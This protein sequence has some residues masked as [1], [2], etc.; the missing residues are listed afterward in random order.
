MRTL[1]LSALLVISAAALGQGAHRDLIDKGDHPRALAKL[2]KD[3]TKDP[4]DAAALYGMA[5]LLDLHT[6]GGRN[7][8]QAYATVL[9]AV[10]AIATADPKA[11]ARWD[12]D[13]VDAGSVRDLR[14]LIVAHALQQTLERNT[15]DACRTFLRTYAAEP[16]TVLEQARAR[17]AQLAYVDARNT[18]TI[19][20]YEQFLREHPG[21][22][23]GAD[24]RERIAILAFDA[25]AGSTGSAP[26][27]DYLARYP[28]GPRTAQA[29]AERERWE[30]RENAR[31]GDAQ[32]YVDYIR[33]N[34]NSA[35]LQ[36][37]RD[38][39]R[40]AGGPPEG[41]RFRRTTAPPG[42]HHYLDELRGL[43]LVNVGGKR[44]TDLGFPL[45]EDEYGEPAR[46]PLSPPGIPLIL[47]NGRTYQGGLAGLDF[48]FSGQALMGDRDDRVE[49]VVG[50]K[51]SLRKTDGSIVISGDH[52]DIYAVDDLFCACKG[53][54]Y[55]KE[56]DPN[57][58]A[59]EIYGQQIYDRL[60]TTKGSC[61]LYNYKGNIILDYGNFC[62]SKN[63]VYFAAEETRCWDIAPNLN[64]SITD[65]L[66]IINN[67]TF[68]YFSGHKEFPFDIDN[69]FMEISELNG[70]QILKLKNFSAILKSKLFDYIHA[71]HNGIY[72]FFDQANMG[73]LNKDLDE[74]VPP[75]YGTVERTEVPYIFRVSSTRS[76]YVFSGGGCEMG[77]PGWPYWN[78][79]NSILKK[80]ILKV[81]ILHSYADTS[82]SVLIY[83][84]PN[85]G[86]DYEYFQ[87]LY[88]AVDFSGREI[89]PPIFTE[90]KSL[91][92]G[93]FAIAKG[94][95]WGLTNTKGD[96]LLLLEHTFEEVE[97]KAARFR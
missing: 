3:L 27:R 7:V 50:G 17:L 19:A 87:I 67:C 20:G 29:R 36:E 72:F 63:P 46:K 66:I 59:E 79:Y 40:A 88:G 83:V 15:M 86:N 85:D 48:G 32:G 30:F 39:L 18:N 90:V 55:R 34:P 38:S 70:A 60:Y 37:A 97:R 23:D 64:R 45:Y 73:V 93:L 14:E 12:K 16:S 11:L 25:L 51:W 35:A 68:N 81:D 76:S 33:R 69:Y 5:Y 53:G 78:I 44:Y 74:L 13:G 95:K 80:E 47:E 24:A 58:T 84:I 26:Y 62:I 42:E 4:A 41:Y 10:Q 9:R 1:L 92:D 91:G 54:T 57:A 96:K 6:Y 43:V 65:E 22:R 31:P 89:F 21:A 8:D 2:D 52:D 75:I 28:A 94:T 49:L 82:S 61:G 71:F 56:W 77:D